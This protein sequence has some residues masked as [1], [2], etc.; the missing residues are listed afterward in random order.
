MKPSLLLSL[1]MAAMALPVAAQAQMNDPTPRVAQG[2]TLLTLSADARVERKPD[3]ANFNAGVTTQGKTA[4]EALAANS[5]A[6]NRVVAALK[7]AGIA[8]RDIQ[9]ANLNLTPVYQPQVQRPDGT[10]VPADPRIIGYNA[11]NT[12]NIRQRDLTKFGAVL[13]TLVEAG[14]NTVNGPSFGL[15][16]PD[17]ALDEARTAAMKKARGRAELYARAAG[18]RVLR[19]LSISESG[20]YAPPPPMP[21]LMRGGAMMEAAPTPV[22]SG[23]VSLTANVTV[24]F[25]LAP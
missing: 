17:T 18:L 25:E 19:I 4:G 15:D 7:Q 1:A 23:E 11:N 8:D 12:V 20:G 10:Y 16:D 9:T 24:L 5:V 22:A 3:L 14:A 2:N 6:M 13:D 21:M